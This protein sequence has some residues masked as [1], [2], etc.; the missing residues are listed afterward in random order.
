MKLSD[1]PVLVTGGTGGIG[2]GIAEA[3]HQRGGRV[4]VCG[5]N[6]ERLSAVGK[7]FPGI[8][9]LPCD[10]GNGLQRKHLAAEV[11]RHF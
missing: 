9:A 6:R 8:T 4:V 1:R 10:V 3:F 11:I 7:K 2:L 5:R